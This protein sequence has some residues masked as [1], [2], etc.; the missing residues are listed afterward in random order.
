MIT[1]VAECHEYVVL[2]ILEVGEVSF[3]VIVFHNVD[4]KTTLLPLATG[5]LP[6]RWVV[7]RTFAWLC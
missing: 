2:T 3:H 5:V 1:V 6:R 7:E 4:G